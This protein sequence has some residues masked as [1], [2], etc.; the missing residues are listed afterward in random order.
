MENVFSELVTGLRTHG[1]RKAFYIGS[2]F[3]TYSELSDAVDRIRAY[4]RKMPD[5]PVMA[6]IAHD[7]LLTYASIIALWAEGRAYVP[8][9]PSS[10]QPRNTDVLVQ[11]EARTVLSSGECVVFENVSL[12]RTD[13]LPET[14][15]RFQSMTDPGDPVA[16]LL[17][18]SGTTGK[19]KGVPIG[20]K[21]VAAF[22]DAFDRLGYGVGSED[23]CLQMFDLTFDLS[24]ISFLVPLLKGACVYTVPQDEIKYTYIH[25]LLEDQAITV[26]LMVPSILNFL[27]PYFD[28][29]NCPSL[30]INLF[31]GEALALDVLTEWADRVPNARVVNVYGPTE[32]TIFCTEMEY[33]RKGA[34]KERNGILAIGKPMHGTVVAIIDE[35]SKPLPA[36][37]IGELCLAGPQATA[38]YWKDPVRNSESFIQLDGNFH[39]MR[40]YR[41]GDRCLQD[42]EG[43]LLY[44]GRV[45]HQV[46]IQGFRVELAEVE[47]YAKRELQKR[48]LVAAAIPNTQG[49]TELFLVVEG[50]LPDVVAF[51][52]RLRAILP[53]YMV[54]TKV[55]NIESLPLNSNGKIDRPAVTNWI[56]RIK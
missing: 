5:E 35:E 32:H 2:S 10:P 44:L 4:I 23:R 3:Y 6:I 36:G 26:A 20:R 41:T 54:P 55:M 31:C 18:T 48:N 39:G 11:S 27:R 56:D 9:S 53:S 51:N 34:N 7:H 37:A 17:F 19:P 14:S 50:E 42:A 33:D 52:K 1:P 40:F 45:D 8:L 47:H 29:V 38:G 15:E 30:R 13:L 21:A 12:V 25:E 28:E 46:K 43:D 49:H 22:V 16:Y 24:V